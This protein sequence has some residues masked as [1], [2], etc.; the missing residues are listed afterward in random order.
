MAQRWM[1]AKLELA[2]KHGTQTS[3]IL[4]PVKNVITDGCVTRKGN[5]LK[6][7]KARIHYTPNP[8][9]VARVAQAR[10]MGTFRVVNTKG[11]A[12]TPKKVRV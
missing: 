4:G 3:G 9:A 11:S 5:S 8:D 2:K 1:Q 7:E 6:R 10:A 12:Y